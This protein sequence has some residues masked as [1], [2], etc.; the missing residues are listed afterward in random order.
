MG[1]PLRILDNR[2][3]VR[4]TL[5]C[6]ERPMTS[7]FSWYLGINLGFPSFPPGIIV[8][9]SSRAVPRGVTVEAWER[10]ARG[11]RQRWRLL[12]W[13]GTRLYLHKSLCRLLGTAPSAWY[14]S[15][16]G[17]TVCTRL[18]ISHSYRHIHVVT[19]VGGEWR[20]AISPPPSGCSLPPKRTRPCDLWSENP[21]PSFSLK[22][23][24]Y[25]YVAQSHSELDIEL[26]EDQAEA[27]T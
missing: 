11:T 4:C 20:P 21:P 6:L 10:C 8:N 23:L 2:C 26:D 12:S 14:S 1:V 13:I 5:Y 9:K 3:Y 25:A 19:H 7:N 16:P 17:N 24:Q 18:G 22:A 27:S 15:P